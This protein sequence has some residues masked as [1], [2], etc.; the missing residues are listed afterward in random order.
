MIRLSD[1]RRPSVE[2]EQIKMLALVV[3]GSMSVRYDLMDDGILNFS[4]LL[5]WIAYLS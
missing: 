5:G 2:R 3:F 1:L 4:N